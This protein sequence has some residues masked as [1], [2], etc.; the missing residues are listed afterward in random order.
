MLAPHNS[1]VGELV[2]KMHNPRAFK[3]HVSPHEL[4]QAVAHE[5][6]KQF[7]L[8]AQAGYMCTRFNSH[9]RRATR[10]SL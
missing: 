5:S 4:M 9:T 1:A 6:K 8:T 2:R 3:T 10:L 7:N